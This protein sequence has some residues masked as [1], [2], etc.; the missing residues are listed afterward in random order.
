MTIETAHQFLLWILL[1]FSLLICALE[2]ICLVLY[3]RLIVTRK[4]LSAYERSRP[5]VSANS[6]II[7]DTPSTTGSIRV[8]NTID[9]VS[10]KGSNFRKYADAMMPVI[11]PQIMKQITAI[12]FPIARVYKWLRHLS[13]KV[14]KNPS[15]KR[16]NPT[17]YT[18]RI[19][20]VSS[21][22]RCVHLSRILAR[23]PALAPTVMAITMAIQPAG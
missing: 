19:S 6:P 17:S 3:R 12:S 4:L 15:D 18:Y 5:K 20:V 21:K 9:S 7:N 11:T 2:I 1:V 23:F 10:L 14:E 22:C 13:T 8:S 16:E